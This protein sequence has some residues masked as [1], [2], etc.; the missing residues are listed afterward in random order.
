[1][2]GGIWGHVWQL[3]RC[4]SDDLGSND[5]CQKKIGTSDDIRIVRQRTNLNTPVKYQE[6]SDVERGAKRTDR[7]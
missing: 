2:A 6:I 1:M 5:K 4:E 3:T 7:E